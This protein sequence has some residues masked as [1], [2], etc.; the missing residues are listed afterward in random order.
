MMHLNENI[1]HR[2]F[3]LL[4]IRYFVNQ[5]FDAIGILIFGM[6]Y[7][8]LN[9][10]R[11]RASL[12]WIEFLSRLS[13][14]YQLSTGDANVENILNYLQRYPGML[15]WK[16]IETFTKYLIESKYRKKL[17]IFTHINT[18]FFFISIS[19]III[20]VT[21]KNINIVIYKIIKII[22]I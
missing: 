21:L 14:I 22:K 16:N 3:N 18:N 4:I 19:R 17:S 20:H 7:D 5:C 9:S 12:I 1:F 15:H 11:N 13:R 6:K 10:G 2:F 8:Y